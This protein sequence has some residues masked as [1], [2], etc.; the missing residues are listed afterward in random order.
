MSSQYFWDLVERVIATFVQATAAALAVN[1]GWSVN[2][3]KIGAAA[4]GLAVLKGVA[5]GRIGDPQTAGV[6]PAAVGGAAGAAVGGAVGTV[7][8]DVVQSVGQAVGDI[9]DPPKGGG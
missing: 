8:G 4:G 6:L 7:V 1:G 9:L 2:A 5:A 3:L